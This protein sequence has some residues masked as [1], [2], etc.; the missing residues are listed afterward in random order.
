MNSVVQSPSLRA[1]HPKGAET[2]YRHIFKSAALTGGASV[3]NILLNMVRTKFMAIWLG[4]AGVG[5]MGAY[6]SLTALATV[7]SGMGVRSSGV[8]EI[9]E[10]AA[11]NDPKKLKI[12][13]LALRRLSL[14]LGVMGGAI[15]AIF[16]RQ[17]SFS[18][19]GDED[20]T[21]S[22]KILSVTLV[23]GGIAGGQA[24][25][26][27]GLRKIGDLAKLNVLGALAGT[28][29][30]IP[31][32]YFLGQNGIVPLLLCLGVTSIVFSWYFAK[33]IQLP[34]IPVENAELLLAKKRLLELGVT[35]LLSSLMTTGVA[36]LT[37]VMIIRKLGLGD[38]GLYSA[39]Y[40]LSAVYVGFILEAMGSD[41]YPRLTAVAADKI[42]VNRMV[43]EQTEVGI[44]LAVPGVLI[45]LTIAP[46]VIPIFYSHQFDPA[47]EV[48][49]WQIL[50]V[51][52]RVVSWPMGF[53]MLARGAK[54]TFLWTEIATNLFHIA[55]VWY[56][57]RFFG[58]KGTGLAFCVL[59][60]FYTMLM[61][62]VSKSQTGFRWNHENRKLLLLLLPLVF[63]VFLIPLLLPAWISFGIS[64]AI[65]LVTSWIALRF[66]FERMPESAF[67]KVKPLIWVKKWMNP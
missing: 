19:F 55:L 66:L 9:S 28:I 10:A 53:I 60:I 64:I 8:R 16:A 31:F 37:R 33:K 62:A 5:L 47:I 52:G 11:S 20:H 27:Q 48:L 35:F 51:L 67:Q 22:I 13:V 18:T 34:T 15:L 45:T 57:I 32:I 26:I 25:L 54:K 50:G 29:I 43:N 46:V 1:E 38:V 44:L 12:A 65:T 42:T 36:Y 58:L 17:V 39:A 4:P 41:F 21:L 24:A 23:M 30:G 61:V 3:I 63:L 7:I 49:R 6:Y 40:T 56:G 2:S 14:I 59:Y